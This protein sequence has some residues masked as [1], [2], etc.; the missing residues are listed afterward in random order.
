MPTRTKVTLQ[1]ERLQGDGDS[2]HPHSFEFDR[3][4]WS[5]SHIEGFASQQT[6][7]EELGSELIENAWQGY[8]DTLFA[9]GQTGS[10]KTYSVIGGGGQSPVPERHRGP[11]QQ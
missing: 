4:Y 8:N 6:L 3:A 7:M 1:G 11:P 9:Y 10:G 5:H 2:K